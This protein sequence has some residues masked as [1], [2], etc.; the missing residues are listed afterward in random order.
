MTSDGHTERAYPLTGPQALS[1][2]DQV[3]VLV[4]VLGR[5]LGYV[6]AAP[7]AVRTASP[8]GGIPEVLAD[9]VLALMATSLQPASATV[10]PTIACLTGHP[11]RTFVAWAHDHQTAFTASR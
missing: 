9:A 1:A 11:A 10:E 7:E 4:D 2:H 6:D 8:D 3:A 5:P